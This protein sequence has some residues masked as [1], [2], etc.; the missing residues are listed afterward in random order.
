MKKVSIFF[1]LFLWIVGAIGGVGYA[2]YYKVDYPIIVGLVIAIL[3]GIPTAKRLWD[4]L[5]Q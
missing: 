2:V 1:L 4:N 5:N 3:F